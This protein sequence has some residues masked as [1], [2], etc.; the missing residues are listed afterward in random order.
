MSALMQQLHLFSSCF[1]KTKASSIVYRRAERSTKYHH[2]N[3]LGQVRTSR[4]GFIKRWR[5]DDA[6]HHWVCVHHTSNFSDSNFGNGSRHA[7]ESAAGTASSAGLQLD[8]LL[9]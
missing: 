7:R 3:W 9:R 5:N 8:G 1:L 6:Q 2:N 4:S